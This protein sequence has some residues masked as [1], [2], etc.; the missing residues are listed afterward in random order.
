MNAE[1]ER[2]SAFYRD[3][4]GYQPHLFRPPYG[5]LSPQQVL[6]LGAK[7]N[8][9]IALWN[10]DASDLVVSF[11]GNRPGHCRAVRDP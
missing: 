7:L 6:S 3:C 11:R 8:R 4:L 5:E 1:L 9:S 2:T 10:N